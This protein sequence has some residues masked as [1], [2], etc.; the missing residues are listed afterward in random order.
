[1]KRSL[2]VLISIVG[3]ALLAAGCGGGASK[4][5]IAQ[6]VSFAQEMIPHH[7]QAVEMADLAETR[8]SDPK[9]KALA[10]QIKGAQD[11]EIQ[12]MTG[13]LTSWGEP[14]TAPAGGGGMAGHSM[15]GSSGSTGGM[16]MGMMTD[17]EMTSLEGS[18][19]TAFDRQFLTMMTGHHNGAID[20][21]K[22]QL[23]KGKFEPAK[24]LAT[25]IVDSQQKEVAEMKSIL[26][27]LPDA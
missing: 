15:G 22:I 21:A 8:A 6:D 16:G 17:A 23:E 24:Q 11:P 14:V 20:M 2:F 1:M 26:A 13:W 18:S 3:V 5:F 25:S 4:D 9:V 7:K 19:G 27:A 12:T 10:A